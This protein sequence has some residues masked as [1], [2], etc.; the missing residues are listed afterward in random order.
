MDFTFH[1]YTVRYVPASNRSISCRRPAIASKS[2][3]AESRPYPQ[4]ER[5]V[6]G[7]KRWFC[8]LLALAFFLPPLQTQAAEPAEAPDTYSD[9]YVV[10]DADTGQVLVAKNADKREYPASITKVLTCALVLENG[11]SM[12]EVLTASE[13]AVQSISYDSTQLY[14]AVGEKMTVEQLLYGT[15]VRSANDAANVLAERISGTQEAFA[16]ADDAESGVSGR[17]STATLSIP[18]A[19]R[20]ITITPPRTTWR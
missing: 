5:M 14:L 13:E 15:M 20:T 1:L 2:T 19:C 18:T 4:K 3:A 12:E 11:I 9:A 17:R 7:L 16:R 6:T 8:L 10:M